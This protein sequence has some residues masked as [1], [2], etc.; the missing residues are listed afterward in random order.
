MIYLPVATASSPSSS[1][2]L[3]MLRAAI[4]P[5][6]RAFYTSWLGWWFE[7]QST[8]AVNEGKGA[9]RKIK[10]AHERVCVCV[11]QATTKIE[12]QKL[13]HRVPCVN[14]HRGKAQRTAKAGKYLPTNVS[15]RPPPVWL[16]INWKHLNAQRKKQV[17]AKA[18]A[19]SNNRPC[20]SK[21]TR[22]PAG[23]IEL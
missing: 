11:A 16:Y 5:F 3:R 1:V 20:C 7:Q 9:T 12:R 22:S 19:V 10:A 18:P 21:D 2:P 15:F 23:L 4:V 8:R 14:W 6:W 17:L 13:L